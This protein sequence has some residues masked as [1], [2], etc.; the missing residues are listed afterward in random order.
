MSDGDF[1]GD[2]DSGGFDGGGFDAGSQPDFS[3]PDASMD[4]NP[5]YG[6]PLQ[7]SDGTVEPP[8]QMLYVDGTQGPPQ[9]PGGDGRNST[10]FVASGGALGNS[11][12]SG[13]S[14]YAASDF[15][16]PAMMMGAAANT[17]AVASPLAMN[18]AA[19]RQP[20]GCAAIFFMFLFVAVALG[21]AG[22]SFRNGFGA[23]ALIP[24]G[25][26]FLAIIVIASGSRQRSVASRTMPAPNAPGFR[27]PAPAARFCVY[28]GRLAQATE[29]GC[30]GCGGPV[31]GKPRAR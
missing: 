6:P 31:D 10:G 18:P 27:H 28:C 24:I 16:I 22:A 9:A 23:F 29:P 8:R 1:G 26:A 21:M 11:A 17:H 19:R 20:I 2:F 7:G 4:Y 30:A 13:A 12:S 14:S 3:P 25:M 5:D 15:L